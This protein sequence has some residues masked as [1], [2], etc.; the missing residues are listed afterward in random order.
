M[1]DWLF[2]AGAASEIIVIEADITAVQMRWLQ[3]ILPHSYFIGMVRHAYAVVPALR[4]KEQY[5]I[6]RCAKQWARSNEAMLADAPFVRHFHLV[7]YEDFVTYPFD[8]VESIASFASLQVDPLQNAIQTGW[9]FGNTDTRT[10]TLRNANPE[11]FT[12]LGPDDRAQV[13]I[14]CRLMLHT[15]GYSETP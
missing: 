13:L 11:L 14:H 1:F 12:R 15:L 6:D 7:R 5:S 9:R 2:L 10:S 3:S 8:I 4:L